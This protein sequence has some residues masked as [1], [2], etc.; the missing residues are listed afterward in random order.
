MCKSLI[1]G[2]ALNV[3]ALCAP[4]RDRWVAGTPPNRG[5][6]ELEERPYETLTE[7]ASGETTLWSS[8]SRKSLPAS[9]DSM[10]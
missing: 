3:D 1:D 5:Q 6:L 9:P 4:S 7:F 8:N 2:R 10:S